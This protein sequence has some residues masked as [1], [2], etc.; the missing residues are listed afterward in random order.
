MSAKPAKHFRTIEINSDIIAYKLQNHRPRLTDISGNYE[1]M[2]NT[3]GWP[4]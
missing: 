3:N 4:R 2:G 1:A